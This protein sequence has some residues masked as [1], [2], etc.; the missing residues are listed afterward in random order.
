M[1]FLYWLINLEEKHTKYDIRLA[2][3]DNRL[4]CHALLDRLKSVLC[5]QIVAKSTVDNTLCIW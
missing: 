5:V 3:Q 4:T 2:I 1:C